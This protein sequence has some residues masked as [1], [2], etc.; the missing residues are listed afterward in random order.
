[1]IAMI[2]MFFCLTVTAVSVVLEKQ[3]QKAIDLKGES[4]A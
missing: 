4:L 3:V 2:I 1:M